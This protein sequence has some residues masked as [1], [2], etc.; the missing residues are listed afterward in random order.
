MLK[1]TAIALMGLFLLNTAAFAG[2]NIVTCQATEAAV[3]DADGSNSILLG[4]ALGTYALSKAT[5]DQY[6]DLKIT[7]PDG[8]AQTLKGGKKVAMD[9]QKFLI[10]G[11]EEQ[12]VALIARV[13]PAS[14]VEATSYQ[15]PLGDAQIVVV[16]F[17]D[18]A[19]KLLGTS[20]YIAGVDSGSAFTCAK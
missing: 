10:K 9:V 1:Q 4:E 8:T 11:S 3:N 13:N 7:P 6:Y 20:G 17:L 16:T 12:A 5:S 2:T 15:F 14:I 18:G 19:G